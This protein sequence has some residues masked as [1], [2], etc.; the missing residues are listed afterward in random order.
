MNEFLGATP[1]VS[2]SSLTQM[3]GIRVEDALFEI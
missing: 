2:Y 3:L 1:Q